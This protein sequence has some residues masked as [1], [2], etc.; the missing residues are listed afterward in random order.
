MECI[1]LKYICSSCLYSVTFT[2]NTNNHAAIDI[3]F[4]GTNIEKV[5]F[6]LQ[7][8]NLNLFN[9]CD[10]ILIYIYK[11]NSSYTRSEF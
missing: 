8:E 1:Y 11:I 7:L 6:G 10:C 4:D 3:S 2:N 5:E 9:M